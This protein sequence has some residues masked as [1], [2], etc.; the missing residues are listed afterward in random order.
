MENN[1][2]HLKRLKFFGFIT[3]IFFVLLGV[4]LYYLQ[5]YKYPTFSELALKQRSKEVMLY[6]KRGIIF[7]RNLAPLTNIDITPTIIL[8]K[9]LINKDKDIYYQVLNNTTLTY[10][11]FYKMINSNDYLLQIPLSKDI[12]IEDKAS[13]I[14]FANIIN[15]YK[16]GNLLSHVIGY[17]NKAENTGEAGLE[18]VYDEFLRNNDKKSLMVEYDKSRSIILG[19]SEYVNEISDPNNPAGVKVTIDENIQTIVEA[20]MDEK[21]INGAVVVAE[22][23][24]GKLLSLASRPNFNQDEIQKYIYN[25]NMALYNKAIQVGYPPGSIF[26]IVVLLAALEEENDF[27]NNEYYCPGYED[28]GNVRIKCTG[29]H[30]AIN[31]EEAFA[32]SCNAAFIQVGKKI[33]G[34][35][36]IELAKRLNLGE[37]INIG[38]LEEIGGNLPEGDDLLG[39]AI[40]NISIGQG[41]IEVTPLQVT[42]LL[43]IIANNGIQK[44]L[45]LIEGITNKDG[46]ILKE[47]NKEDDKQLISSEIANIT[48]DYLISVV[49]NGTGKTIDINNIGGAGGKT[50]SAEAILNKSPTIHGWFTGFFPEKDPKYVITVLIEEGYS[51]SKSAAPIFEEICK[52]INKIYP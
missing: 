1:K 46:K 6:P 15:R 35:K 18:K 25:N 41:K 36:I 52:E 37:K 44:H 2:F 34:Y 24:T 39:A 29:I 9:D 21:K 32:K 13:S 3:T 11:E 4:R 7:D 51:G 33:G 40:G 30:G 12:I 27:I 14:F 43:M 10:G 42:N 5:V 48:Y 19:G 16:S 20:I 49:K 8:P 38:L 22:V 31:L 50:G 28:I 26:K 45:T 23:K 17:I 47:F